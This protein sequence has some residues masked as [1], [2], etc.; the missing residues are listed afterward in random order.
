VLADPAVG[1]VLEPARERS[2]VDRGQ[3]MNDRLLRFVGLAIG[4]RRELGDQD[5]PSTA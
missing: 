1:D 5:L 2:F 3:R 4:K